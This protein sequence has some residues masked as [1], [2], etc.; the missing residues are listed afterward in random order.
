MDALALTHIGSQLAVLPFLALA[1]AMLGVL[2]AVLA[3]LAA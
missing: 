2:L 3:R 1:G